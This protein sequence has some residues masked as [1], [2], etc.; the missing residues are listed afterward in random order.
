MDAKLDRTKQLANYYVKNR[1]RIR[2][3]DSR[4]EYLLKRRED[5]KRKRRA[6]RL[7]AI[8]FFGGKCVSCL[9]IDHVNGLGSQERRTFKDTYQYTKQCMSDTT[10]KYQLLCAN[11][12]WIKR[13]K[14]YE[15]RGVLLA[16]C[17]K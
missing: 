12:N 9:Q 17:K 11:C 4:P 6:A 1:T 16:K 2:A 3:R 15:E 14:N 7:E 13:Y 5:S 10:G 8:S